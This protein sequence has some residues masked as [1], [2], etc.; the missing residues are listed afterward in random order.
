MKKLNTRFL[1]V[2]ILIVAANGLSVAQGTDPAACARDSLR[3]IS[4]EALTFIQSES[5]PFGV[6]IE[7]EDLDDALTTCA[8]PVIT[9]SQ[10]EYDVVIDGAYNDWADRK[11]NFVAV[12]RGLVGDPDRNSV[13]LA[14][15]NQNLSFSG[16]VRGVVNLSNNGGVLGLSAESDIWERISD[17][18]VRL[19]EGLSTAYGSISM[20]GFS[21]SPVQPGMLLTYISDRVARGLWLKPSLD[22]DWRRIAKTYFPDGN[23]SFEGL[24][25]TSFS[26]DDVNTFVVGT[27]QKGLYMTTDGGESFRQIQSEFIGVTN[28]SNSAITTVD[29]TDVGHLYVAIKNAGLYVSVDEGITFDL[30]DQMKIPSEFPTSDTLASPIINDIV[31][32]ADSQTI[33][34]GLEKFG[35]YRSSDS[36]VNWTWIWEDLRIL[37]S[38]NVTSIYVDPLDQDFIIVGTSKRGLHQTT[39]GGEAWQEVGRDILFGENLVAPSIPSIIYDADDEI[40]VAAADGLGLLS[41][42]LGETSWSM[43]HVDQPRIK[44][45]SSLHLASTG[46]FK[47]WLASYGGGCYQPQQQIN[48]SETIIK[49]SS[50]PAYWGLD[51][52][53]FVSFSEG[54]VHADNP[55]TVEAETP[56]S[57]YLTLQDYQGYAVWRSSEDDPYNMV[58]LGLYD[59]NNPET[60]MEGYC[61]DSRQTRIPNCYYEK[62]AACFDFTTPGVV[63]FFD[64]DI[65]DG[66]VYNYAVTS[67]DYGNTATADSLSI[68]QEQL[69]SVRYDDDP[70]AVYPGHSNFAEF[71]VNKRATD[72]EPDA[73]IFVYPNPLRLGMGFPNYEGEMVKFSNLPSDSRVMI[74]T[75]DGD[76]VADLDDSNREGR[77]LTWITRN[78]DDQLLA[79]GVYIYKVEMAGRD[80]YFGK[81]VIIR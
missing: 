28:W 53:L 21:E 47:Y 41:C 80:D 9:S 37:G 76:L 5:D 66:F 51:F 57:F 77:N 64:R 30:L 45:I 71:R 31:Y 79:S 18:G 56:D 19:N 34:V 62:R 33:F 40:Y 25:S 75:I 16:N 39:N 36:G 7:W 78:D 67:F 58:I 17:S 29:W 44:T 13:L 54:E 3:L 4:P 65:Y 32:F 42:A 2:L 11:L 1:H 49:S 72:N 20:K 69:F 70:R 43:D 48:L 35:I 60:C 63:R 74:F 46:E 24:T 81:L 6:I 59:K 8:V 15:N 27:R 73:E 68:D 26:P 38:T 14:W 22:E 12:A 55:E 10:I 50:D 52:G 61:G 23:V